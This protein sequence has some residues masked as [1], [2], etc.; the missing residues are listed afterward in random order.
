MDESLQVI[1]LSHDRH[2]NAVSTGQHPV[3]APFQGVDTDNATRQWCVD[4]RAEKTDCNPGQDPL[5]IMD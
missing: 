5:D 1:A 4:I 3:I 2:F